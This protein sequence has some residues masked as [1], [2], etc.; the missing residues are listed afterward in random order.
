MNKNIKQAV[1]L[2]FITIGIIIFLLNPDTVRNG[3]IKGLKLCANIII[4]SLFP[5]SVLCLFIAKSECLIFFKKIITPFSKILFGLNYYAFFAMLLSF[6]G[7]YPVGAKIIE[8]LKNENKISKKCAKIMLSYCINAGPAFI[9]IAVGDCILGSKVLGSLLLFSHLLSSFIIALLCKPLL[10]DE[11]HTTENHKKTNII[12]SDV[13]V[14]STA[15]SCTAVISICSFVVLFSVIINILE[16]TE[17]ILIKEY[18][19]PLLEVT[20]GITKT[21][22]IYI[23]SGLLGWGGIC[24]HCQIF[25]VIKNLRISKLYF[26]LGRTTHSLLS[27]L[28]T[29]LILKFIPLPVET[30]SNNIS[31][32]SSLSSLSTAG[33]ISFI[34]SG[35]VLIGSI[36]FRKY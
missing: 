9:I 34:L 27:V 36:N 5:F 33:A 19:V 1:I 21:K 8:T 23:I 22:N 4:P 32:L 26:Y 2:I 16:N 6:L 14:Q 13:L 18:I 25:S 24:V 31:F 12:L 17:I 20:S 30:L 11:V 28:I 3:A 7:G 10:K 15:D 35:F 29:Y